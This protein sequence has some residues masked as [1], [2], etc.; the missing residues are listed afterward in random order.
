MTYTC[1][2]VWQRH[3]PPSLGRLY[4]GRHGRFT[5]SSESESEESVVVVGG[6]RVTLRGMAD[7]WAGFSF[8]CLGLGFVL[9]LRWLVMVLMFFGVDGVGDFFFRLMV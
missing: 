2:G 4:C 5:T 6:C 3:F 1:D 8:G 9:G 7:L